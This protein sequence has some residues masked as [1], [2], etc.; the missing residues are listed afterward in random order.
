MTIKTTLSR[1][2]PLRRACLP[3]RAETAQRGMA[4]NLAC[5]RTPHNT[6]FL[7]ANARFDA[8]LNYRKESPLRI[9]NRKWMPFSRIGAPSTD[10]SLATHHSLAVRRAQPDEW[11][12]VYPEEA[13]GRR[14][15]TALLIYGPAIRNA[16][17]ALKIWL[18]DPLRSTVKGGAEDQHR[19]RKTKWCKP[20]HS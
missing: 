12:L 9:S 4:H 2:C 13:G 7:I 1:A 5:D 19:H 16:P 11:S 20:A 14:R 15:A 10:L 8:N 3:W 18:E 17:K 6:F